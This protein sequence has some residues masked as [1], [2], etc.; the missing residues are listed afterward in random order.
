MGILSNYCKISLLFLLLG[1]STNSYCDIII[2]SIGYTLNSNNT[3]IVSSHYKKASSCIIPE[4]I[5]YNGINYSVTSIGNYAFHSST[6]LTSVTVPNS[7]IHIGVGAFTYCTGLKEFIVDSTNTKYTAVDGVLFDKLLNHLIAYPNT[8]SA[9]YTVPNSVTSIDNYAFY[10]C[11]SLTSVTIPNNVTYIGFDAFSYCTSLTSITI[12]CNI[13]T[14][15]SETFLGCIGLTSVVIP[16]SVSSIGA[17]AFHGCTGLTSVTIG[18]SVTYIANE[19]FSGCTN[20]LEVYCLSPTPSTSCNDNFDYNTY[21]NGTLYVPIG[22]INNYYT[23]NPW[24]LF[25]NIIEKDLTGIKSINNVQKI[26]T[27]NKSII[28]DNDN[29]NINN[30]NVYSHDGLLVK[31]I[32][33]DE[34]HTEI[35]V[36]KSGMYIVKTNSDTQKVI[37]K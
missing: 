28:I 25:Y 3:A 6:S 13:N 23:T 35:P 11:A 1:V 26:S 22:S 27:S 29:S 36:N 21:N 18:N 12:P 8:K 31:A 32:T 2:D 34:K 7:I 15:N 20:L 30:I 24:T 14:I 10:G 5:K 17:Y 16:N 4:I 37:V 33:T 9:N 19:V